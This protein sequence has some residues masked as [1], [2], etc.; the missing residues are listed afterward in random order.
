M[1]M[2]RSIHL[3]L[4][5]RGDLWEG[6]K[7]PQQFPVMEHLRYAKMSLLQVDARFR[8]ASDTYIFAAVDDKTK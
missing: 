5:G 7:G 1:G 4:F 2:R 6:K 3:F 8:D